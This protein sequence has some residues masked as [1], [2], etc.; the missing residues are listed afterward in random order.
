MPRNTA[1]KR[2]MGQRA[3]LA[4]IHARKIAGPDASESSASELE[5]TVEVLLESALDNTQDQLQAAQQKVAD[6]QNT[7]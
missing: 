4:T 3:N 1:G 2:S 5:P 7:A 6:L